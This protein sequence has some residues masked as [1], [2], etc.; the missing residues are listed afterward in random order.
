MRLQCRAGGNLR[1]FV[2]V[3]GLSFSPEG[4]FMDEKVSG[5]PTPWQTGPGADSAASEELSQAARD[6]SD[7]VN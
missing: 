1:R 4:L 2:G 6:A 3:G 5:G 7:T